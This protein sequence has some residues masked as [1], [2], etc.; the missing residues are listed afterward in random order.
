MKATRIPLLLFV[1][2]SCL[3]VISCS[4]VEEVTPPHD[5]ENIRLKLIELKEDLNGMI[6]MLKVQNNSNHEIIQNNVYVSFP[7]LVENGTRSNEFKIEAK[8][9]KLNIKPGEEVL[10][11]AFASKEMYEG[12]SNIDVTNP[13]I[14]ING[15]VDKVSELN[16][17]HRGGGYKAMNDF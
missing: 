17:F 9:N 7:I 15:Y 11:T 6:Y 10:L 13:D 8:N 5:I 2:L 12:N 4:N 1:L 3:V 16:R 14:E